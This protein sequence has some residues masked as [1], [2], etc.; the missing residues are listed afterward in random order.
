MTDRAG[1]LL[2]GREA[3]REP[4][5]GVAMLKAAA[6][7]GGGEAATLLATL[8]G[9]GAWMPQSWDT[10]LDFLERAAILGSSRARGQLVLLAG[11]EGA[12]PPTSLALDSPAAWRSLRRRMDVQAW[13]RPPERRNLC[14]TPRVRSAPAFVGREVC[15][16]L[17]ASARGKLRPALMFHGATQTAVVDPHRTCSD[18]EFDIVGSDLVG[19]L[20]RARIS[21]LTGL[22]TAT[23]EPPRIFHY[24]VGQDIKPHYD[25]LTLGARAHLEPSYTGDRLV[26]LILYLNDD[27][28]GGEL[29]FPKVG[30]S[31]KGQTGDAIYFAHVDA[32][33]A[34]DLLSLHAGLPI[35]RGEKWVLSQW[36]HDRPLLN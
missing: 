25:R 13:L 26:T 5:Q 8:A 9:A 32:D 6:E 27:F 10:A 17:I 18:F 34:P 30:K 36:I 3:P 2:I 1:R 16:W 20:L 7:R 12:R 35:T 31:F 14:E 11:G 15:D 19:V 4:A 23:M 28:D 29:D 22:P 21:A 33:G 24:A